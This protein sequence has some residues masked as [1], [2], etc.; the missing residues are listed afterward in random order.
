MYECMYVC[1]IWGKGVKGKRGY[2]KA[3]ESGIVDVAIAASLLV[4]KGV[5]LLR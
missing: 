3:K 5:I 4:V 2:G 1:W